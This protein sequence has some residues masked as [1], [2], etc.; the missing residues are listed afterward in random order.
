M[1]KLSL[2]L[3]LFTLGVFIPKVTAAEYQGHNVD[4]QKFAAKAYSY[5]T[6]GTFDVQVKFRNKKATLYFV[7]GG[8]QVIGLDRRE[9]TDPQH[10]VGWGRPFGIRLGGFLNLG[11]SDNRSLTNLEPTGSSSFEGLWS[12]SIEHDELAPAIQNPKEP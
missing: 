6:G 5:E 9:I 12:I 10:I 11:L 3:A 1:T 7:N 2:G 4:G 8:K